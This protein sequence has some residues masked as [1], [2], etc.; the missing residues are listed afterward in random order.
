MKK[1]IIL[2][3]VFFAFFSLQLAAQKVSKKPF[4]RCNQIR[5]KVSEHQ[6]DIE[7][8]SSIA[9]MLASKNFGIRESIPEIGYLQST[10]KEEVE[11]YFKVTNGEV[12]I[13]GR[14][15]YGENQNKYEITFSTFLNL[16]RD[17]KLM[18][19]FAHM[20]GNDIEYVRVEKY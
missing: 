10:R 4:S 9:E 6:N 18:D 13:F 16:N 5:V 11:Y 20:L 14:T 1:T 3:F 15:I 8:L 17:F 7:T 2:P 12:I 19:D